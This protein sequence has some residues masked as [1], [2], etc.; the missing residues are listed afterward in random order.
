MMNPEDPAQT[1]IEMADAM[2]QNLRIRDSFGRRAHLPVRE[3]KHASMQ[4]VS[5]ST[6]F[7]SIRHAMIIA[8]A[9]HMAK[10]HSLK[11]QSKEEGIELGSAK[12]LERQRDSRVLTDKAKQVVE[13][14][15]ALVANASP[16]LVVA[17]L[18][19]AFWVIDEL[20]ATDPSY[21]LPR[22][23]TPADERVAERPTADAQAEDV[24]GIVDRIPDGC[25]EG[26][27][28]LLSNMLCSFEQNGIR[29]PFTQEV[30]E[31]E[32]RPRMD[33][34][35]GECATL[36]CTLQDFG[37]KLYGRETVRAMDPDKGIQHAIEQ[38]RHVLSVMRFC[39]LVII[40]QLDA[41]E[42]WCVDVYEDHVM[43]TP[44][45]VAS[46]ISAGYSLYS[47][48]RW[49][50]AASVVSGPI[51]G[52]GWVVI[53]SAA[54]LAVGL[55]SFLASW[56]VVEQLPH[57]RRHQLQLNFDGMLKLSVQALNISLSPFDIIEASITALLKQTPTKRG[58]L[59]YWQ[60]RLK[61]G[62]K[63]LGGLPRHLSYEPTCIWAKWLHDVGRIGQ[64]RRLVSDRLYIGVEGPTEAGKSSL[65]TTLTGAHPDVFRAGFG[66]EFRTTELQS[67]TPDNFNTVF[68]DCPGSDDQDPHIREMARMFRDMMDVIIFVIPCGS[69]RAQSTEAIYK[70][71]AEFI[72]EHR[73]PRPFRILLNKVD[74]EI[75]FDEEDPMAFEKE[76]V[77]SKKRA[78][79]E[80]RR[81][82][83]F[84]ADYKIK[85]RQAFR[86]MIVVGTESLEDVIYPFSTYAQ[87][88][89]DKKALSD[90]NPNVKRKIKDPELHHTLYQLAESGILWD[91]ES[92][93]AWLRGL[94]PNG[95]PG[96]KGRVFQ[97]S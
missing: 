6:T 54:G 27:R 4:D 97:N 37:A 26:L 28:A 80:I 11:L 18:G 56:G 66:S 2:L 93:R 88:S 82:G 64:L 7:E 3:M 61:D 52:A 53:A 9:D 47:T 75:E 14:V 42:D 25:P 86:G 74:K 60:T 43:K 16:H 81:L 34:A 55:A 49:V 31:R 94:V 41:P 38:A 32:K 29:L 89:N 90:C 76:L 87:M 15:D 78:V 12:D 62:L 59:P 63:R 72:G 85:S 17:K 21:V 23:Q 10:V 5:L 46:I 92:L 51:L 40:T 8:F 68:C 35:W 83:K 19:D 44:G 91:I 58:N 33:Q 48:T 1:F 73:R 50:A 95:V 70:E 36:A 77:E 71:I 24:A 22:G 79:N 30:W 20:W 96:S 69:V 67:Y 13:Q 65:L 57:G 45:A 39:H 84:P